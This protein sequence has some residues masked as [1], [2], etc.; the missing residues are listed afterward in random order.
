VLILFFSS[1]QLLSLSIIGEY[2]GRIFEEVKNRPKFIV[3]DI[4]NKPEG[5]T[6]E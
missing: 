5:G 6:V 4:I 2:L 3:K 1:I